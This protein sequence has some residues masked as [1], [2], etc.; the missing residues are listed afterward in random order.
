MS[1]SAQIW[2]LLL[3]VFL[4]FV[5]VF[6]KQYGI[7]EITSKNYQTLV[8]DGGKDAWVVA[9]KDA[10]KISTEKWKNLEYNLRGLFVRVGIIDPNKDGAFLK[11]NVSRN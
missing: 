1:F 6:S 2:K 8:M 7:I 9:V 10:G 4:V 5:P 11:K 3:G